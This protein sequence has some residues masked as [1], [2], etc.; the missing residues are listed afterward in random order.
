M[1]NVKHLLE[2][3]HL[4]KLKLSTCTAMQCH[5]FDNIAKLKETVDISYDY[6]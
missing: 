5:E 3:K 2:L 6:E 4:K 1:C